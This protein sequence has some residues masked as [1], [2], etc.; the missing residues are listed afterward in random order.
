MGMT[1]YGVPVLPVISSPISHCVCI[2]ALYN[3]AM[4]ARVIRQPGDLGYA[5]IHRADYV[6]GRSL[7]AAALIVHRP[8]GVSGPNIPYRP[9][10]I[11]GGGRN[12][13]AAIAKDRQFH[14]TCPELER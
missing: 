5:G 7:R 11:T 14:V 6:S 13:R 9:Q 3:R 1:V 12:M 8:A 4:L 2:L 10:R